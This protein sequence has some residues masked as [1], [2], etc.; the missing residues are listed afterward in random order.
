MKKEEILKKARQD[1]DEMEQAIL[2]QSLG[3][4]TIMIP[5]LCIVFIVARMMNSEYIVSDLVAI[6]LAQLSMS[7]LYQA[8]KMKK[9][10]L[11]ITGIITL[12]LTV[13][14]TIGF[15]NEVRIWKRI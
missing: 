12:I 1:E 15:I 11:F 8:I 5:I 3:I 4:S 14:F 13:I 2:A 6:T 9:A 10:I 7:Q